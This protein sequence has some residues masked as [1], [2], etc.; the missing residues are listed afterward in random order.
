MIMDIIAISQGME[1]QLA[2]FP[3][4]WWMLIGLGTVI[5][6]AT[7]TSIF[8]DDKPYYKMAVLGMTGAG[9]TLWYDFLC[10]TNYAGKMTPGARDIPAFELK[11]GERKVE[12]KCGKDIGGYEENVRPYYKILIESN[13]VILFFFDISKYV[14]DI[15]YKRTVEARLDFVFNVIGTKTNKQFYL[16]MTHKDMLDKNKDHAKIV[17]EL[18]IFCG[19]QVDEH[20]T[21]CIN[22]MDSKE[23][24]KFKKQLFN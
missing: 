17:K 1:P 9:K 23:K 22:M 12:I 19:N 24:E 16:V 13:D 15:Q 3:L 8:S 21:I 4:V 7:L 6:G 5:F 18:M 11:F 14:N 2:W 20:H 10:G